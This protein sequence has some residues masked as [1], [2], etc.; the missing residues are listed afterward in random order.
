MHAGSDLHRA[1]AARSRHIARSSAWIRSSARPAKIL[2]RPRLG[3][4]GHVHQGIAAVSSALLEKAA[5]GIATRAGVADLHRPRRCGME[6][7]LVVDEATIAAP[8]PD[9]AGVVVEP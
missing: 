7:W 6:R 9:P 4:G 1:A 2:D 5:D 3:A 8:I